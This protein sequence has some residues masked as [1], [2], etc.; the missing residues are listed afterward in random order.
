MMGYRGGAEKRKE[1][2]TPGYAE[3]EKNQLGR[4]GGDD[5]PKIHGVDR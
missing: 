3:E 5:C 4:G 1:K 2:S